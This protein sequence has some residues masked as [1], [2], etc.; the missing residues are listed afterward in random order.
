[1]IDHAWAR[2]ELGY[3]ET[4]ELVDILA[5]RDEDEWRP[6]IFPIVETL[7][8]ER[9][10][11]VE[12]ALADRRR[13]P[14]ASAPL[15]IAEPEEARPTVLLEIEDE[16]EAGLCRMALVEAGIQAQL[17]APDGS[18]RLQLIVDQS[19]AEAAH[20]VLAEAETDADAEPGFRCPSCGFIADPVEDDGGLV[21]QV[22]GEAT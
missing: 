18:G 6:E 1:V 14:E 12:R 16:V 17:R 4:E 20:A 15:R 8:R 10:V 11:D 21:C 13:P 2:Q 22:C 19:K 7:L 3:R 9:G 5:A